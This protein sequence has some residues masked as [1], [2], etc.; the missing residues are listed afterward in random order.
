MKFS[1]ID[2]EQA[3]R[4]RAGTCWSIW[5]ILYQIIKLRFRCTEDDEAAAAA[6][7]EIYKFE[8]E[9]KEEISTTKKN[10]SDF[11]KT[12]GSLPRSRIKIRRNLTPRGVFSQ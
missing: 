4:A 12:N 11:W 7:K 8:F 9:K 2:A 1:L 5:Q 6:E 10:Q 3:G